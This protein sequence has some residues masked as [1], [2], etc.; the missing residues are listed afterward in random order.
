MKKLVLAFSFLLFFSS[1]LLAGVVNISWAHDSINNPCQ[2]PQPVD[3]IMAGT[4]SGYSQ[5]DTLDIY[6]AFG[7]GQSASFKTQLWT[8]TF[9]SGWGQHTYTAPGVYTVMYVVTAP[10]MAS[11]TLIIPNEV[12]V[13]VTCENVSGTAY[14]DLNSNCI[15]DLT[16]PGLVNKA[17]NLKFGGQLVAQTYTDQN[18]DYSLTVPSGVT[19]TLEFQSL[20]I[21]YNCPTGGIHTIASLPATNQDFAVFCSSNQYDL[22]SRFNG[23]FI[24]PG[25]AR[26]IGFSVTNDLCTPVSGI[27]KLV[28]NSQVSYVPS[29]VP[30]ITPPDSID[31]DTLF[32]SF[33]ASSI[34]GNNG[35]YYVKLEG[36]TTLTIND[37]VCLSL[38]A[39]PKSGDA[40]PSNNDVYPCL[41]V[42]T[43]YDPNMKSVFPGGE[44]VD[45]LIRPDQKMVYTIDFQN[46]G[47]FMATNV[48]VLDT[49]DTQTLDLNTIEVLD[50]SH[51]MDFRVF[52]G[53]VL[54]FDFQ[55]I[56]LPDSNSN[57]PQSH[58]FVSFSIDQKPALPDGSKI[59]NLV[60]IYFDFNPPI[61]TNTAL[62]TISRTIGISEYGQSKAVLFQAFPNPATEVLNL[63]LE[64]GI[65]KAGIELHDLQGKKLMEL[66]MTENT[67]I[68][69]S[70]LPSGVYILSANTNGLSQQ[71]RV[72]IQ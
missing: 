72:V 30:S 40:N 1:Q 27:A 56:M 39:L 49:I 26:A 43:S 4:A 13:G 71:K 18:G 22:N 15:K 8:P 66:S 64:A 36:D 70:D 37:T 25:V 62:N 61:I 55:N 50:Y 33:N 19:Y 10:D 11:D 14:H 32:F 34:A 63:E 17:V 53:N 57:E 28:L 16:E 45:G 3:F 20:P 54:K 48:F 9:W 21:S 68:D 46:T 42:R 60:G 47:N 6:I 52:D 35:Y 65:G 38:L 51:P 69:V 58:G 41:S 23:G 29:T 24:V 5:G 59:E 2:F 67:S 12:V 44:G 31:G 7:D